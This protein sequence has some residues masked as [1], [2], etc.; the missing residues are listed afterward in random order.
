MSRKTKPHLENVLIEAVAAEGNSI[1]HVDGKH[2]VLELISPSAPAI[3]EEVR[4][5]LIDEQLDRIAEL[6]PEIPFIEV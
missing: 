4:D 3:V 1:A 5:R 6:A 2:A